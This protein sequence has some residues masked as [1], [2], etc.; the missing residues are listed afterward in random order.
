MISIPC[1]HIFTLAENID[2]R[3]YYM[4]ARFENMEVVSFALFSEGFNP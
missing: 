3:K 2:I 4:Y 1:I